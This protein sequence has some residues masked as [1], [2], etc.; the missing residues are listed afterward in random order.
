MTAPDAQGLL[1]YVPGR[2]WLHQASPLPK[3]AWLAG[4]VIVVLATYEPAVLV[5]IAVLGFVLAA[6]AGVGRA[7]TR[8]VV[9]LAPIAASLIVLQT[10]APVACLPSCTPVASLGPLTVYQEGMSHALALVA[11]LLAM[12]TIG[13]AML[14][15]THPSDLFAALRRLH[16]P[17][18]VSLMAMLSLQL[19]P[20]LQRELRTVLQAQR[21]RGLRATGIGALAPTLVPVVAGSFDRLTALVISLESRG[22]GAGR[23]TSY[24]RVGL[25]PVDKVATVLALPV[26]VAGTA[27]A[28]TRWGAAEAG[29]IVM[30]PVVAMGI[31][32]GAAVVFVAVMAS[33]LRALARG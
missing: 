5:A 4:C 19:I 25:R 30:P 2:S 31:V 33:G 7:A 15:T 11:R 27:L 18:E 26:T 28:I 32:I 6:S 9:A 8:T 13:V 14:A 23:R 20:Q 10:L 22:L 24:R 29:M 1:A 3:L 16:L 12:E 21:S 17:Y